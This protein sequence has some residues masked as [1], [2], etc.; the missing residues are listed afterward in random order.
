MPLVSPEIVVLVAAGLP[1][2]SLGVCA[3]APMYGV[4]VYFVIVLPPSSG[5]DQLTVAWP[6]PAVA[7]GLAGV[8]GAPSVR[9][10]PTMLAT[11]GTPLSSTM[12]SM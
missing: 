11:E 9:D 4:T 12:K 2:T 10:M 5:A 1:V 8:A 3:A 6:S 7:V